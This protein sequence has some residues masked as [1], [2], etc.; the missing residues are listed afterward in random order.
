MFCGNCGA[1][2][3]N[4]AKFCKNCGMA[5]DAFS[6]G[7]GAKKI[8]LPQG[9]PESA[10]S[11]AASAPKVDVS[12][13][14]GKIKALPKKMLIGI[15]AAA[16]ALIVMICIAVNIG[17]TIN[18]NDYLTIEVSGYDGYG[19]ARASIDWDAIEEKYGEKLSF[20]SQAENEYGGLLSLM[21]P[22]DALQE[23]INVTLE[24]KNG[25]S[26]GDTIVYTWSVDDTLS[27]YVKCKVKYKDDTYSVS[28]L[29]EVGTFDA[30]AD[31]EVTFSGVAPH[32]SAN[33][34]YTGSELSYYD[35]N[36]DKTSELS[37]GDIIK[38]TIDDSKLQYYA[39]TLGMVP[40]TL[41]KEYKVDG[42]SSYLLKMSEIN[43][44]ALASMQQQA[45]DV[46]NEYIAQ[47]WGEN[48]SLENFT[49]IGNYLLTIQDSDS[50]WGSNNILYMIY[51]AQVR[52]NYS[53]DGKTYNKLNDIY[54]YISF[55][56]LMVES[57]GK[58]IVDLTN[59]NTPRDTF[60]ID[61]GVNNGWWSTESW[62]YYGY[63]TLEKLY[64]NVVTK[65]IDSYNYES[66]VDESV[67]P[68]TT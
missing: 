67:A 3:K 37:D 36:C 17:S 54:W 30:F 28:G 60:T 63:Q 49:Y 62:Y 56:D 21:T 19:T 10:D 6:G 12:Q 33:F 2:N 20:T 57:D 42:L 66:N 26:N 44:E 35:F 32:G 5:L 52:N 65:N 41:E 9:N 22:M 34:N 23:S 7:Q 43:D 15:F 46:F 53:N 50:Y 29:T 27:T 31:F 58:L 11:A 51:K 40:E 8:I 14:T 68:K 1:E 16:V 48:E 38:V 55:D 45:S 24:N 39:E 47:S 18:L 59:Y 4:H 25:L 61:S 13:M 64:E